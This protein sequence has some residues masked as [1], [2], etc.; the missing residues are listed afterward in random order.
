MQFQPRKN[1]LR[2]VDVLTRHLL[3]LFGKLKTILADGALGG[4]GIQHFLGNFDGRKGLYRRLGGRG[5]TMA[6]GIVLSK[7]LDQLLETRTK[8]VIPKVE[9]GRKTE[10]AGGSGFP[11]GIILDDELD[12]GAVGSQGLKIILEEEKRI[13]D[14][15]II[16]AR[17]G[18]RGHPAKESRKIIKMMG[19]V[20]VREEREGRVEGVEV[21]GGL[22]RVRVFE[23]LNEATIAGG[24]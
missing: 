17:R 10:G 22:I 16:G 1:A 4:V 3:G 23:L 5:R 19:R 20:G 21:E 7:L 14:L 15:R 9:A 24:T 2:M 8:E 6:I 11:G 12:V 13:E 18:D